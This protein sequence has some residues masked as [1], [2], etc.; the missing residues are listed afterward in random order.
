MVAGAAIAQSQSAPQDMKPTM[1]CAGAMQDGKGA[2]MMM[3]SGGQGM[4]G[5][6]MMDWQQMRTDMQALHQEIVK[7]RS[8]LQK[9]K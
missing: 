9:R 2:G 6:H 5:G 3:G 7:L 8:E 4:M 1:P